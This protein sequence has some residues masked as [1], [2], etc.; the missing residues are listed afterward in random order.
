VNLKGLL[1]AATERVR[2]YHATKSL[3]PTYP[4]GE[5]GRSALSRDIG[6]ITG[7]WLSLFPSEAGPVR[8]LAYQP[9]RIRAGSS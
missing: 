1:W 9:T 4:D 8:L 6:V 2:A 5:E 7:A 3:A